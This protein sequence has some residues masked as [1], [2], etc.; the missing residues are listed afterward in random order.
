MRLRNS[1]PALGCLVIVLGIFGCLSLTAF[2]LDRLCY[3]VLSQR[4]PLYP[5]AEVTRRTHNFLSEFGMGITSLSLRSLDDPEVV[6][7][8]YAQQIGAYLRRSLEQPPPL[9]RV[10]RA[11]W[12]VTRHP[13]GTGSQILLFGTCIN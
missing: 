4:L 9:L 7:T 10:A 1:S 6:R 12:D 11:D 2:T 8:W 3:D 5:N 13:E